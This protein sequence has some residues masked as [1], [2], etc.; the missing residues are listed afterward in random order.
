MGVVTYPKSTT[1]VPT[2]WAPLVIN[3][4]RGPECGLVSLPIKS[5]PLLLSSKPSTFYKA[6]T[7]SFTPFTRSSS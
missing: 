5:R 4:E 1:W 3:S 7:T 6:E 2:A